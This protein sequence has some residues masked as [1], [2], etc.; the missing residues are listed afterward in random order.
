V[1]GGVTTYRILSNYKRSARPVCRDDGKW[2]LRDVC[3]ASFAVAHGQILS[4]IEDYREQ[5]SRKGVAFIFEPSEMFEATY[6][7]FLRG[8]SVPVREFLDS[9]FSLEHL[10]KSRLARKEFRDVQSAA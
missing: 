1:S 8:D 5:E 9:F 6:D 2:V 7:R 3:S 4:A 10:S